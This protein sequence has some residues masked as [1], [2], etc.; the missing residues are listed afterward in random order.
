MAYTLRAVRG[1]TQFSIFALDHDGRCPAEDFLKECK[2]D[3]IGAYRVFFR[4][5]QRTNDIG[6]IKNDTQFKHI[7]GNLY[8]FKVDKLR[9]FCFIEG[10]NILILTNE[11]KKAG[12]SKKQ[13]IEIER[14]E[15]QR[16]AYLSSLLGRKK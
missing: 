2:K 11:S 15:I 8:E 12:K 4:L 16:D 9:L 1:G 13:S 3:N 7:R 5:F 6:L 14:A 10:K